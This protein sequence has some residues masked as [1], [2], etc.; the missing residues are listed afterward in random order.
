MGGG[1]DMSGDTANWALKQRGKNPQWL[2]D[3]TDGHCAYCGVIFMTHR[4]MTVDH[5]IPRSKG[6]GGAR[7]NRFPCC[8]S[9]NSTKL[10]RPLEY[11]RDALQRE[12][13]GAP[14][15]SSEQLE[16][17]A[18]VGIRLPEYPPYLFYWEKLGNSFAGVARG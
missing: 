15:F 2:W 10:N 1:W 9:C 12:L 14:R 11:L 13:T 5:L 3:L 7:E 4:E 8:R 17:L 18:E 16:Y 6:G